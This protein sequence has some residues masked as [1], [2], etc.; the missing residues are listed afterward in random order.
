MRENRQVEDRREGNNEVV[1]GLTE[2]EE[3]EGEGQRVVDK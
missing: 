2:G 3:V 1:K